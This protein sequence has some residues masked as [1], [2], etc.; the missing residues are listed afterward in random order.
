MLIG[1]DWRN[2]QWQCFWS[3]KNKFSCR[4]LLRFQAN[5]GSQKSST[6]YEGIK[7]RRGK[8]K[9]GKG[10]IEEQ[11]RHTKAAIKNIPQTSSPRNNSILE[12]FTIKAGD[13]MQTQEHTT[14][15]SRHSE[16]TNYTWEASTWGAST[17]GTSTRGTS[18]WGSSPWGTST[19]GTSTWG[20]K[21]G[22]ISQRTFCGNSDSTNEQ[23]MQQK[24]LF[25]GSW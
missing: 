12:S 19:W 23:K 21:V 17:W 1:N 25:Y 22:T 8:R 11:Q 2:D 9:G 18:P 15:V 13:V 24:H 14:P 5:S 7:W 20:I 16:N 3:H 6:R 4:F 10:P